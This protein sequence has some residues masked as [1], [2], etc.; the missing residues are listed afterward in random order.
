MLERFRSITDRV[1]QPL[2]DLVEK[3]KEMLPIR[4][5]EFYVTCSTESVYDFDSFD[6]TRTSLLQR[7][8]EVQERKRKEG[9][10][11]GEFDQLLE[12]LIVLLSD[13][14]ARRLFGVDLEGQKVK[15]VSDIARR[16]RE[17]S[18][19]ADLSEVGI[20]KKT[21]INQ[22]K[23]RAQELKSELDR[24]LLSAE[25]RVTEKKEREEEGVV[26]SFR[27]LLRKKLL[28]LIERL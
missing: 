7:V 17:L 19:T 23:V 24:V 14:E 13:D 8:K 21:D 2:S 18:G 15:T 3:G 11:N 27:K 25:E 20:V 5:K 16:V 10:L 1:T 4:L 26:H 6:E 9:V 28:G 22:L 12:D